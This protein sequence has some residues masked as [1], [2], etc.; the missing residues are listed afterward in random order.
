MKLKDKAFRRFKHKISKY[1][2]LES[3]WYEFKDIKD[4]EEAIEWLNS[5]GIES[6]Y[7]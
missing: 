3:R 2:D 1:P 6:I 5:L 4:K 7:S